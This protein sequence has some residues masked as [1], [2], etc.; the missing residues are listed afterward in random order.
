MK[1][2]IC[3]L[4]ILLA[5]SS[6]SKSDTN[7]IKIGVIT[8]L[9][10]QAGEQGRNWLHG[11]ELAAKDANA[12]GIPIQLLVED[13][14]TETTKVVSAFTKLVEFDGVRAIVGGT[15]DY[16]GEA[17]YPLAKRYKIPF[18]TPSN[19]PEVLSEAAK[20]SGYVF[21]NS[22]TLFSVRKAVKDLLVRKNTKTL[23]LV[24]PDLPFGTQ[25]AAVMKDLA[26]ELNIP[27]VYDYE[28]PI[29][30]LISDT[31]KLATLKLEEKKPDFTF[32][33]LN[34]NYIDILTAE[35]K[36]RSF[37]PRIL[38]TQH[39][40]QALLFSKDPKRYRSMYAVYPKVNDKKFSEDFLRAFH[41]PSKVYAAHGYDAVMFLAKATAA[42]VHLDDP[43]AHF[44]YEGI[45]GKHILPAQNGQLVATEAVIMST[46]TGAFQEAQ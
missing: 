24:Y 36:T 2:L 8:S 5:L 40:D 9:N 21:S 33:V 10:G 32:A 23:G 44:L 45:T 7:V 17:A 29:A 26:K 31:M 19:P 28:F 3:V 41:E 1:R 43:A 12:Q 13:D 35:F 20:S 30:G 14:Q 46:E 15:W 27:I 42:G 34:Y 11:A 18:V 4:S 39:L 37:Y 25:Q 22:M 16:L 6:C 38:T